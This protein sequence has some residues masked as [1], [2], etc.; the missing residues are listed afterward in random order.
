[1][2]VQ[3]VRVTASRYHDFRGAVTPMA[4]TVGT[5]T[6]VLLRGG[7]SWPVRWSRATATAGTTW[8]TADGSPARVADGPVWVLLVNQGRKVSLAA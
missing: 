8:A 6:G 4:H 2:L 7:R 3:Y 1:M 5:G